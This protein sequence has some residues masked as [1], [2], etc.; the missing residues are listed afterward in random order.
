MNGMHRDCNCAEIHASMFALLDE[1]LSAEDCARLRAHLEACPGCAERVAAEVE[2]RSLL[3]QC[4][5]APAPSRLR[6]KITYS[7]RVERRE[8]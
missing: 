4:C 1:E 6:Q 5:C 7:I 3:R 8:Y 2:L